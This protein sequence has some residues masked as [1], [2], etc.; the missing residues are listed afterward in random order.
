MLYYGNG[1]PLSNKEAIK[2]LKIIIEAGDSLI[3]KNGVQILKKGKTDIEIY[4]D[5]MALYGEMLYYGIWIED[6]KKESI[7]CLKKSVEFNNSYGII[8]YAKTLL[9]NDDLESKTKA[10]NYLNKLS[11]KGNCLAMYEYGMML[12]TGNRIPIDKPKAAEYFKKAS[13]Y[14]FP[15][16]M[17]QYCYMLLNG[18]GIPIDKSKAIEYYKKAADLGDSTAMLEYGKILVLKHDIESY[19]KAAELFKKCING[20]T[21]ILIKANAM[22][23]YGCLLL[24]GKVTSQNEEEA[25]SYFKKSADLKCLIAMAK[26]SLM[27]K[28]GVGVKIDK[29]KSREYDKAILSQ[30]IKYN[31]DKDEKMRG[32]NLADSR[33][34]KAIYEFGMLLDF[35]SIVLLSLSFVSIIL[36]SLDFVLSLTS[37][38]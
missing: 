9:E 11:S 31:L 14:N 3:N 34:Y 38:M 30:F 19:K 16:A 25:A 2:Y 12:F 29:N 4:A 18:D 22:Y 28:C 1:I 15:V 21:Q 35:V 6:N 10:L 5:A 8:V 20:S 13:N 32:L 27:L 17:I 36:L 24:D 33:N 26:Y 23:E 7:K 37:S